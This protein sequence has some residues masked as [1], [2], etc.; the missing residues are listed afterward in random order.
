MTNQ[1]EFQTPTD[2]KQTTLGEVLKINELTVDRSYP[3]EEIE[4]ID[5]ASVEERKVLQTQ[6][7][8][9][10]DAPSR[11]KRIVRDDDTL[12]STVRPNLKHYCYIKK[13][14]PNLIASTGFAVITAKKSDSA[15]IY[16][17]LTTNEYTNYLTQIA[18]GHTSAYP[19]FNPDIIENSVFLMPPLLE[20]KAIAAVLSSFDDK[21]ESLQRQNK[22]LEA[23]AQA[24]FKE[25]FV[26]FNF[27]DQNGKPYKNSHRKMKS[28]ELGE[29]PEGWKVGTV[30]DVIERFSI[31]YRCDKDDLDVQG[32]TPIIDQGSNGLYGYTQR[33]P[34]FLASTENPVALFANHTCN[35]WFVNYPF[36]AIQNIIP[37]RGRNGY[38][39]F[40]AFY[41]TYGQIS[42]IEYKGHWPDFEQK[43]YVIPPAELANEFSKRIKP[44]QY[45]MWKNNSQIQTLSKLRDTL[46]PKLM[47]GEIRVEGI[48]TI[49]GDGQ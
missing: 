31:T 3:F 27:P 1:T 33:Q 46:L 36:C 5:I 17:L 35:M 38:D 13:A 32:K 29:I 19:S 8:K 15:F 42:F 34:D 4:Y 2:W 37:F 21:I 11:A 6:K 18:E 28:S 41:M 44:L 10:K 24:I 14:T 22:T 43:E 12:I 23:M 9:L 48:Q 25:W 16:Y 49:V 7:L 30:N 39:T 26:N 40:F 20:Q 47:K 45:K